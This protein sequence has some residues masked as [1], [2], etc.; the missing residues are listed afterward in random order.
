MTAQK[1]E[2]NI[3]VPKAVTIRATK[4][5]TRSVIKYCFTEKKYYQLS[6]IYEAARGIFREVIDFAVELVVQV[7]CKFSSCKKYF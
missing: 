6:G 7:Q 4:K 1:H 2:K 3:P 5:N